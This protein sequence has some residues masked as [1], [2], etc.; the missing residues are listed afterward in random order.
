MVIGTTT[1]LEISDQK[2]M[3]S[4]VRGLDITSDHVL[5]KPN[6]VDGMRA[7]HIEA[8]VLDMFLTALNKPATIIESYT[9][10]RTDK[11]KDGSGDYFSSKEAGLE[12][13][14]QH[15][16][17]FK[18]QD[19]WFL[20][21]E[22]IDKVLEKHDVEYVNI[23]NEVW[24]GNVADKE[25]IKDMVERKYGPVRLPEMYGYVPKKLFDLKGSNLVSLAKAKRDTFY[26]LSLGIKN[27]FGLIPDP[28]RIATY[29]GE[30]DEYLGRSILDVHRIYQSLFDLRVVVDGI[31]TAC[32][33][34]WD[35]KKAIPIE[36]W[37]IMI[38]GTNGLEVDSIAGVLMKGEFKQGVKEAID[39][40]GDIFGGFDCEIL[41]K[42][43]S[44]MELP[45]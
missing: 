5:I 24:E 45:C 25:E 2:D 44:I 36:N 27:L 30:N 7:S 11:I 23:T 15:W 1:I 40:Y 33:M 10:W 35:V 38:G 13:G 6:W 18:K 37:G 16:D 22:G 9:F 34:D 32:E 14:R 28:H 20:E 26:G 17:H 19:K 3:D 4:L 43:P 42:V 21:S 39:G 8:D 41:E 31:Y 12:A 29:H